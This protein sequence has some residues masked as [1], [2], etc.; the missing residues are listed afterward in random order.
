MLRYTR[1]SNGTSAHMARSL[2][3]GSL[4]LSALRAARRGGD[5]DS[6]IFA[7]VTSPNASQRRAL[8]LLKAIAK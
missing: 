4:R 3:D 2:R 1:F 5:D 7:V 6:P 8:S